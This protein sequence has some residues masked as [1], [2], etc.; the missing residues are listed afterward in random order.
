MGGVCVLV[1]SCATV[2]PVPGGDQYFLDAEFSPAPN[3]IG[4]TE[5]FA[6][7]DAMRKY[8]AADIAPQMRA[9]GRL[10]GLIDALY[11]PHQLKLDYDASMTRNAA[12]AFEARKGNCLSLAIMTAAFAKEL[13]LRPTYQTVDVGPLWSRKGEFAFLNGHVNLVLHERMVDAIGRSDSS[14]DLTV[15]FIPGEDAARHRRREIDEATIVAMFM[16]NRAAEAL[17]MGDINSANWW[18][19]TAIVQKPD[20][21][22]PLNTLGLV[23]LHHGELAMAERVLLSL[24]ERDKSDGQAMSNLALVYDHEGRT[25]DAK[26]LRERLAALEPYPPYYYFFLGTAAMERGDFTSARS[27]FAREVERAAYS[28]EFHFW[29]GIANFKLGNVVEAQ[30]QIAIAMENSTSGDEHAIYEAKL[31]RLRS[32]LVH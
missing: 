9:E 29:L 1:A 32:Y 21:A 3:G 27:L 28:G 4:V 20:F 15:D 22:A 6:M 19:R 7:S 23:Y 18:A 12:Q 26:T 24:V 16:N 30:H 14:S 17:E 31:Q 25:N 11:G 5:I 10:P 13:N 8:L 2:P